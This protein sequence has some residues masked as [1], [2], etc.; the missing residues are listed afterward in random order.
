MTIWI[1]PELDGEERAV[2]QYW[3]QLGIHNETNTDKKKKLVRTRAPW[4]P[5][6]RQIIMKYRK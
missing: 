1:M 4:G 6:E 3:L 5:S 2:C